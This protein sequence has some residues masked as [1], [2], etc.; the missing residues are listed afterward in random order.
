[1]TVFTIYL[2]YFG[3]TIYLRCRGA[4]LLLFLYFYTVSIHIY[5]CY[6][7]C[8]NHCSTMCERCGKPCA[9]GLQHTDWLIGLNVKCVPWKKI[10]IIKNMHNEMGFSCYFVIFSILG[11]PRH[12]ALSF[13]FPP[14]FTILLCLVH[15]HTLQGLS[16]ILP[17]TALTI[18]H[19]SKHRVHKPVSN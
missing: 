17:K 12:H 14:L 7:P 19:C 9:W 4:S 15:H 2:S 8:W 3:G 1:M 18:R 6:H 13:S 10:K 5:H 16:Y 11:R